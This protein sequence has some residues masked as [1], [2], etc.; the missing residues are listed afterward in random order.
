MPHTQSPSAYV[1]AIGPMLAT[2]KVV[3]FYLFIYQNVNGLVIKLRTHTFHVLI[4]GSEPIY[5][6]SND[7][8]HTH[9]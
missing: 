7:G 4:S 3:L 6:R 9:V 8:R 5:R 2:L 1:M